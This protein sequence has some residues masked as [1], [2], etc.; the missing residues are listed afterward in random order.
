MT[1]GVLRIRLRRG[2]VCITM[3]ALAGMLCVL[4]A[5]CATS[6]S[7]VPSPIPSASIAFECSPIYF[8]CS[9]ISEGA[10]LTAVAGLGYPV[11]TV[12]IGAL[13]RDCGVVIPPETPRPCPGL[14]EAYVSFVGTDKIAKVELGNVPG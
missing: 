1:L 4:L 5:A 7:S 8:R 13:A 3:K 12:T 6:Q 14:P 11:K 9:E 2:S 10:V